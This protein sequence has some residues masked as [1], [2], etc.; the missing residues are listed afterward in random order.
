MHDSVRVG[1]TIDAKAPAGNFYLDL[2]ADHPVVLIGGGIGITP[3]LSF[4]P[5]LRAR[6]EW[7]ETTIATDMFSSPRR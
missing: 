2:K 3:F 6:S 1:E 5:V 4:F 7:L